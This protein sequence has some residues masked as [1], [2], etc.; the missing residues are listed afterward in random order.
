[1]QECN[2]GTCDYC[3]VYWYTWGGGYGEGSCAEYYEQYGSE[4]EDEDE[5]SE[6]EDE[7]SCGYFDCTEWGL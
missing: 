5:D 3:L 6:D 4:D 2:D 1:M 7:E